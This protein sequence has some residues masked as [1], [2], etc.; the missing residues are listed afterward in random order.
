MKR[1]K[2]GNFQKETYN[3]F[4]FILFDIIFCRTGGSVCIAT[5]SPAKFPEAIEKSGLVPEMTPE[6]KK[7]F[8]QEE[9]YETMNL[10]QDW[11]RM[12]RNKIEFVTDRLKMK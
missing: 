12:L 2:L 8:E 11:E 3:S 6:I 5:A 7:L 9:K 1:I 10:G 4:N